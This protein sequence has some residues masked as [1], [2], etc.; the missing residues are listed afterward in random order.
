MYHPQS[1]QARSDPYP[2][3][4]AMREQDPVQYLP[5]AGL[6]FL[7]RHADCLAV[8]RDP[9]FSAR[10]GQRIRV[11]SDPLPVSMLNTD[12]P[13]H[14]VLRRAVV[15]AFDAATITRARP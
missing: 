11:R 12:P 10:H 4:Q 15:P 1:A 7:T 6:W 14:T 2:L 13:Q 9:R 3:Y 5:S 8:L